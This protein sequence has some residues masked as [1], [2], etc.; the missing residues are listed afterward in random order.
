MVNPVEHEHLCITPGITVGYNIG[1]DQVPQYDHDVL[2]N[3]IQ[4]HGG[5]HEDDDFN[6]EK[7]KEG[8]TTN[9]D[10]IQL[11]DDLSFVAVRSRT[12]TSAGM[13]DISLQK[14]ILDKEGVNMV[15]KALDKLFFVSQQQATETNAYVL[16]HL[17]AIAKDNLEGQCTRGHSC[18]NSSVVILQNLV[19]NGTA[20]V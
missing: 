3:E 17:P 6:N 5:C 9:M 20:A 14:E 15:W 8:G 1:V 12:P 19:Q 16:E 13:K 10:C 2:Y 7:E 4:A 11:V 18:K